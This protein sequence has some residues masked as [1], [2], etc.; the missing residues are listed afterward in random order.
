VEARRLIGLRKLSPVELLESCL[1]RIDKTNGGINAIVAMDADAARTRAKAVEQAIMRGEDVG[2]IAG[3][4]VGVKDLQPTAGLRTT[5]G[6]LLFKDNVPAE[7]ESSVARLRAAGGI[8]V[9]KTNTPEFGAGGNTR[10]RVYGA[11]GNPFDPA[12]TSGGSSGGSAAT[13]ALGQVALATGSDLGGSL[14]TPAG[15]CGVVGFRPS[16]GMVPGADRAVALFPFAVLGPMGRT[17]ADA[18]LLLRAQIGIDRRDPFSSG[19]SRCI[20]PQL[21]GA[22]LGRLRVA[23]SSDLG[24]APVDKAIAQVFRS[25][26]KTFG[27]VFREV[28]ERA[29]DFGPVHDMFEI[30]RAVYFVAAHRERLDKSRALLDRN[31]IDNTE[32]GMRYSLPDVSRAHVEQTKLYKRFLAFFET[33]DVLICPAASVSPFPHAQLFVEEINGEAMPTYMRWLAITYAPTLGLACAAVL[34]CGLDHKGLPFGIQVIGPNGADARVLEVAHALE[35][36]LAEHRETARPVPD[37]GGLAKA[38]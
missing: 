29:P 36:E 30:H 13:L 38:G 23:V 28:E 11:T 25:R 1:E 5:W 22:D 15:F 24:C 10:N 7:D 6:S 14:R 12:K 33:F 3:L 31:V 19:D 20:P 16:P 18:H 27:G 26:V 34:P 9:G 35:R 8:V 4:P 17:V 32:R 2:L 37:I 21:S